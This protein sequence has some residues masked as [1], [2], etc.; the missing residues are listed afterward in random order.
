MEDEVIGKLVGVQKAQIFRI[1]ND[2]N[3]TFA[4]VIKI[5]QGNGG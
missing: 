1:E 4:T 3:L 2:K 5:I